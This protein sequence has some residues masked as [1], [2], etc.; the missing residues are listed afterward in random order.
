[1][2]F[3]KHENVSTACRF[4]SLR[5]LAD[6]RLCALMSLRPYVCALMSYA[7]LSAPLCRVSSLMRYN[8]YTPPLTMLEYAYLVLER[9]LFHCVM[10]H[11]VVVGTMPIHYYLIFQSLHIITLIFQVTSFPQLHLQS[12]CLYQIMLVML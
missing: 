2:L 10:L 5:Q 7:L 6:L 3:P 1:M 12:Q 11:H 9:R 4:T 8:L